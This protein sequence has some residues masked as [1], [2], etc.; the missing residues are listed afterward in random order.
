MA[1][2]ITIAIVAAR[3]AVGEAHSLF[4]PE[5]IY[6]QKRGGEPE[7]TSYHYPREGQGKKNRLLVKSPP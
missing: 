7:H 4:G 1:C 2:V 6:Q 3:E 5:M